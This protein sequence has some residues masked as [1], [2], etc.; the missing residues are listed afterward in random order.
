MWGFSDRLAFVAVMTIHEMEQAKK[1]RLIKLQ[2][3]YQSCYEEIAEQSEKAC[4]VISEIT[5]RASKCYVPDSIYKGIQYLPLYAF[6]LVIANLGSVYSEQKKIISMFFK[7]FEYPFNQ[8]EYENMCSR[9]AW[10]DEFRNTIMISKSFIGDF[11]LDFFRALYKCGTQ[12]DYQTVIDCVTYIVMRFS[13]LGNTESEI[14]LPICKS[15][16]EQANY[17]LNNC[18]N[19]KVTGID[20]YGTVPVSEYIAEANS[21]FWDIA[22]KAKVFDS[23]SKEDLNDMFTGMVEYCV[24]GFILQSKCRNTAQKAEEGMKLVGI[25]LV[26]PTSDY[27]R[28][29]QTNSSLGSKYKELYECN[30]GRCGQFWGILTTFASMASKISEMFRLLTVL[31]SA[32]IGIENHLASNESF[33]GFDHNAQKFML[34]IF[35][36]M[37]RES[38]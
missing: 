36:C 21:I 4:N 34:N 29:L 19:T 32:M 25:D 8:R 23:F 1:K 27:I 2:S 6:G 17:Q 31:T 30:N 26:Q 14:A 16:I 13:L 10:T 9:K 7:H 20:W 28:E 3:F 37:K 22:N 24:C 15:F 38:E 5:T 18:I 12:S 11:W 35:E 33:S